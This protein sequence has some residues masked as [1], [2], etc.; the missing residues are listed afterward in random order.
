MQRSDFSL[1]QGTTTVKTFT[2]K[3]LEDGVEIPFDLTGYEARLEIKKRV[4]DLTALLLL[5]SD[6][7]AG[8]SLGTPTDGIITMTLTATQTALL[9]FISAVYHLEL[10]TVGGVVERPV[11]GY[12]VMSKEV[13]V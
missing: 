12:I 5:T 2:L 13:V 7:V 1:L 9:S 8:L 6:P 11:G 3:I 10:Y 4:T